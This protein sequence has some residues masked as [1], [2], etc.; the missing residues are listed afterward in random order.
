MSV[1]VVRYT[2]TPE[3]ADQNQALIED[4]FAGLHASHPEG[5]R[6]LSLRLEDGV[7]FVHVAAVETPDGTNPLASEPAFAAFQA[8]I[9]ERCAEQPVV[10][11][12]TVVGSFGFAPEPSPA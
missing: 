9:A 12:A 7:S 1:T 4:V 10:R 5:L 3:A 2:T 6:Y 11:S 8:A